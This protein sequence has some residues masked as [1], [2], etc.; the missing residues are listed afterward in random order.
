MLVSA[1][2]YF[3]GDID[4]VPCAQPE[5]KVWARSVLDLAL[6]QEPVPTPARLWCRAENLVDESH[7][8]PNTVKTDVKVAVYRALF[9]GEL[10]CADS[11]KAILLD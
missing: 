3:V 4:H 1:F 5:T 11:A 10:G 9:G 2:R 7:A 8:L 6:Q